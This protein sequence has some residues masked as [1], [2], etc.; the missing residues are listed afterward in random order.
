MSR[1][2]TPQ[3]QAIDPHTRT[4][5]DKSTAHICLHVLFAN[6]SP[7]EL[8]LY[9][10]FVADFLFDVCF[11]GPHSRAFGASAMLSIFN[12]TYFDC[13]LWLNADHLRCVDV[14]AEKSCWFIRATNIVN[15]FYMHHRSVWRKRKRNQHYAI[16][17]RAPRDTCW[18]RDFW[19]FPLH[20]RPSS[21]SNWR[22]LMAWP[23][24]AQFSMRSNATK[25]IDLQCAN[26][27]VLRTMANGL[28]Q[29]LLF[30]N[31]ILFPFSVL[32]NEWIHWN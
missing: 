24:F 6:Y 2:T 22:P 25:D 15:Y 27:I 18:Q 21:T 19:R 10:R 8:L 31:L 13:L 12:F 9:L 5:L 29:S 4:T 14:R 1:Q 32:R 3:T 28:C 11:D 17:Q 30:M 7:N 23:T 20:R 26:L 16:E